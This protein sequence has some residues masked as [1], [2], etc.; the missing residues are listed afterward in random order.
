MILL[1][2]PYLFLVLLLFFSL[3]ANSSDEYKL[4]P[5]DRITINVHNEP[6][7]SLENIKIPPKGNMSFPLLGVIKV[8]GR[9]VRNLEW[10]LRSQ[11]KKGILKKP[12]ISISIIEYRP[13]FVNGQVKNPGAFPYI[14]GLTI[15]KA[16][17][18]AGGLNERASTGKI[19]LIDGKNGTENKID[20]FNQTI[21]PGDILL[22]GES[23]F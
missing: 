16:L 17:S 1:R 5:G 6:D 22:I 19:S 20:N 14:N 11:L 4:G 2:F 21:Q 10:L 12:S 3:Q 7:L 13:F 23:L 15:Q 8:S 18:I 9:T